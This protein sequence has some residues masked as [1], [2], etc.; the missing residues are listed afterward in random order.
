[1]VVRATR[2][3]ETMILGSAEIRVFGAGAIVYACPNLIFHYVT[4]HSY[5][6]PRSF[7]DALAIC[8]HPH[9]IEYLE[10][11]VALLPSEE[12]YLREFHRE[13][14]QRVGSEGRGC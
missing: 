13:L 2:D 4:E 14:M 3:G 9:S 11:L 8:P 12:V 7:L 1:M 10:R 5:L 6:P